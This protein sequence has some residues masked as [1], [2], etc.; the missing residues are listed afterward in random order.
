MCLIQSNSYRYPKEI[1]FS[2]GCHFLISIVGNNNNN[3]I[4]MEND[5]WRK[6]YK[7]QIKKNLNTR[8]KRILEVDIIKQA[9]MK[10]KI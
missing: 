7:Y 5:K 3:N 1:L 6:E 10:E 2:V 9:E 8:R 4:K